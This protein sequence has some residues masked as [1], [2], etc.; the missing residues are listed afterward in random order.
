MNYSPPTAEKQLAFLQHIQRLLNEGNF[1]STYKFALLHALA[2][3]AVLLGDDTGRPLTLITEQLAERFLLLYERQARP[4]P[5]TQ[6]RILRQNT[7]RQAKVVSQ[8]GEKMA[9][10]AG[11]PI[12]PGHETGLLREIER[13]IREM[14]LGRLQTV[15]QESL[16]F[17]YDHPEDYQS[18]EITLKP[19]IAYC[20]RAFYS[21]ITSLVQGAWLTY[22]RRYNADLVGEK[23]DLQEFMFGVRR[24]SLAPLREMLFELQDGRCFY[25][26]RRLGDDVE[27]DHFIPWSRYPMDL[28]H[29]FVLACG[30]VNRKKSNHI[31]AEEHL[32]KWTRFCLANHETLV[33]GFDRIGIPHKLPSSLQIARWCYTSAQKAQAQVWL[34]GTSLGKLSDVWEELLNKAQVKANEVVSLDAGFAMTIS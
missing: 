27:V 20:L 32:E 33:E 30:P 4:F 7:G 26:G 19:G 8:I 11:R 10:Y 6:V 2:D 31:A 9:C 5:G 29:N 22:V 13:T 1:V 28:G 15:G 34:E 14:P 25:T 16:N 23:V 17:L 18:K 21:F 24:A 3:L 12:D